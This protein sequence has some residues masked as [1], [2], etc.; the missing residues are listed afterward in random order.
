MGAHRDGKIIEICPTTVAQE[1]ADSY[2]TWLPPA[3]L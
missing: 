3:L 1:F 2:L